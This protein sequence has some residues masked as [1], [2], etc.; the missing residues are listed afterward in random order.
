[1][2]LT[3][4]IDSAMSDPEFDYEE[5][6][7]IYGAQPPWSPEHDLEYID[8]NEGLGPED[9]DDDERFDFEAEDPPATRP[10]AAANVARVSA[11]A[12]RPSGSSVSNAEIRKVY[13]VLYT[14]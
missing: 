1:M 2:T 10:S 5:G 9:T 4:T 8:I 12:T 3:F 7:S 14:S 11:T 13:S 6:M